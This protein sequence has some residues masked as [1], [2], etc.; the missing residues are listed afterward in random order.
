ML[1]ILERTVVNLILF[2]FLT[3]ILH[4]YM[5]LFTPETTKNKHLLWKVNVKQ[6]EKQMKV[7]IEK[8]LT[9][10][11]PVVKH[12]CPEP[13]KAKASRLQLI[14]GTSG[15]AAAVGI[16]LPCQWLADYLKAR[17]MLLLIEC[18]KLVWKVFPLPLQVLVEQR[19]VVMLKRTC[20]FHLYH[21]F[22]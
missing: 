7:G 17:Q 20:I 21:L 19:R 3:H 12:C 1:K 8:R 14:L 15:H 6:Q 11:E 22:I 9:V 5:Y 13:Q 2:L 4:F 10:I 16:S 18:K